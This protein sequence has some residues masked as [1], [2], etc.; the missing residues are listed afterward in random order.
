MRSF[1]MHWL[2]S[3]LLVGGLLTVSSCKEDLSPEEEFLKKLSGTWTAS[4]VGVTLDGVA[5]NGVFG[6]FSIT[7]EGNGNFTTQNGNDPIWPA[8]GTLTAIPASTAGSFDFRRNDGV[9]IAVSQI[10]DNNITLSFQYTSPSGRV[11]SVS[12]NYAFDLDRN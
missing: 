2:V 10:A 7:I 3:W 6:G 5:V 1:K 8:T 4:A 9:E 11:S 12:G